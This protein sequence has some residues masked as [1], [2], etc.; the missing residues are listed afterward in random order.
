MALPFQVRQSVAK[1]LYGRQMA[2]LHQAGRLHDQS[3]ALSRD[4]DA[5]RKMQLDS[6]IAHLTQIRKHMVAGSRWQLEAASNTDRDKEAAELMERIIDNG[7]PR[8]AEG[9]FNLSNAVF[10]GSAF[11][12]IEGELRWMNN[13]GD[14]LPHQVWVPTKL[15]DV[16]RR[17]FDKRT[18]TLDWGKPTQ[19]L[20]TQWRVFDYVRNMW[21]H[22]DHPEWYVKHVYNDEEASLGYG[23]G[24]IDAM[25]F[26]WRAKEVI[27][28]FGLQSVERWA[29]GFLTVKVENA[30]NASTGKTNQAIVDSFIRELKRQRSQHFFI[31][32][33][34]DEVELVNNNG[35]GHDIVHRMLD[36]CDR[37]L[38]LLVLGSNLPTEATGGG[39]FNLAEIQ[40]GTTDTLVKYDRLLLAE[41]LT[42]DLIGLTWNLNRPLLMQL[43]LSAA[44]PPRLRI[45]DENRADPKTMAEITEILLRSG[46]K[47]KADETY[48]LV[49]RTQPGPGDEVIEHRDFQ[50]AE[51]F[52][53]PGGPGAPGGG[54][55]GK[56]GAFPRPGSRQFA[57]N[58]QGK[59]DSSDAKVDPSKGGN[60]D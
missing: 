40:Q 10:T 27:L 47:L 19:R 16:D 24:L 25:F 13:L 15:R 31:H 41:T 22:W 4:P 54:P 6:T 5:Y 50:F 21:V 37:Q 38:R 20:V 29:L 35:T 2:T 48:E 39:S 26:Y 44:E 14:G 33:S 45:L 60:D 11:A 56:D 43:G 7:M 49:G 51:E 58:K 55:P 42:S 1:D 18:I 53:A 34:L 12:K 30:R 46:I 59:F 52:G 23:R 3:Y 57:R 36:Y 8:F 28:K 32:D 17:R 9:R